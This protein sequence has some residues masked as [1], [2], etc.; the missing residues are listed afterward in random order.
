MKDLAFYLL[1]M[2]GQIQCLLAKT[3]STHALLWILD[4]TAIVV[5]TV[6]WQ[7]IVSQSPALSPMFLQDIIKM[8]GVILSFFDIIVISRYH[9]KSSRDGDNGDGDCDGN[10]DACDS[11]KKT[12][13]VMVVK[14]YSKFNL[15]TNLSWIKNK[16]DWVKF[17]NIG[18][19]N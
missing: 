17:L 3:P 15:I 14:L 9:W 5:N 10:S 7:H 8:R 11:S 1:K 2:F 6:Y 16:I 19:L 18:W 4:V 12:E 13:D